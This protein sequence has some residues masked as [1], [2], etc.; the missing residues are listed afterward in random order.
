MQTVRPYVDTSGVESPRG[1]PPVKWVVLAALTMV[2]SLLAIQSRIGVIVVMVALFVAGSVFFAVRREVAFLEVVAFLIH[3]DGIGKGPVSLGR[4]MS[5]V[6]IALIVYKLLAEGWRPP[7]VPVRHWIGPFALVTWALA[8][9]T[10]SAKTGSWFTGMGTYALAIAYFAGAAFLVDSH[11]KVLQFLRAYWYG[12]IFGA[13]SGV[14]GL[15]LGVRSYGFNGDSNLFGV[16]AAS[17]IP[18]TFFYL[19]NAKTGREK[20]VY[21][22]VLV[23]VLVGAA[24]AGSRSGLIG[25]AVALFG[26]LVYRPGTSLKQRVGAV[27]PAMV[28]TVVVAGGLLLL[29]PQT[30][31]RGTK[32]SGRLDFWK[33]TVELIQQRP[34]I[35]HGQR[36]VNVMIPDLLATT[37]GTRAHSDK[38]DSVSSHNTWLD[39]LG[40]LGMIGFLIFC[41]IAVVTVLGLL[42]PRWKQTKEVSGY[43]LV[44]YLPVLS[45]SM[46]LDMQNNKL[47]WS[48]IGLAGVLQV[49][50]WGVRYRGYFSEPVEGDDQ[51]HFAAPRLARWDVKISRR[52]RVWV[53]LG[54]LAGAVLM[55]IVAS[56]M[57]PTHS[58]TV[59][60]M[61]PRLDLPAGFPRVS[62]SRKK[63]SVIHTLALSDAYGARLVELSGVDLTASE[64]SDRV[65][66]RRP[67]YGPF[68][69]ITFTDASLDVVEAVSPHLLGAMAD[70][71]AD[72]HELTEPVLR[73]EVR[74]TQPGEQRYYTGPMYLVVS[75]VPDY[76]TS[77]PRVSWFVFVGAATGTMVALGCSL[78]MQR[79]P[80]VNNDDDLLDA[81]GLPLWTHVGRGGRRNAATAD[82]YSQVAIR[83]FEANPSE[84]WPRAMVVASPR[85]GGSAR[86]LALG[87]AAAVAAAGQKVV[88]VDG[89][90]RR[91]WLSIRMGMW[92]RYGMID[93]QGVTM[94]LDEV[95]TRVPA[96]RLPRT[97]RRMLGSARENLRFIPAG[98]FA[99]GRDPV[100]DP[101]VLEG[102][103]ESVT[104][105][106]LAPPMLGRV[107]VAGV[108]EWADVV[109]YDLVEGET[110]TFDAEDGALPIATFASHAGVVLSDV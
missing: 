21:R 33:V 74:P 86:L 17:M 19:R 44:M 62:I 30:I 72:G 39:L 105:I 68:M 108:L 90:L 35:G 97:P 64:M 55:G 3:F 75:E 70:L 77:T 102:F 42:R 4:G 92:H 59:S 57:K 93:L 107:A 36:Q 54:G 53:V 80:R 110:V 22:F 37:P 98:R 34:V 82:Q 81:V 66:V 31:A 79:R 83:A 48:V 7:A 84:H 109:M 51:Q 5:V 104:V 1:R 52:F 14:L 38:R 71:V 88:L 69:Q 50:S 91:P 94:R 73:D 45:G 13:V 28:V 63:V 65:S 8:S 89:W 6:V 20:A 26:S 100:F 49:P 96:I 99:W 32:T 10:W 60:I 11:E 40:N 18:L 78:L 15:V 76:A 41:F 58:G 87:T 46:F 24:G 25:A 23:L 27:V 43:I 12:G 56:G 101:T 16:L 95:V 67:R 103:D 85:Y 47:G 29:N 9:G 106:V 61:I 2:G